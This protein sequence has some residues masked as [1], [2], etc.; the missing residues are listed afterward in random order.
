MRH[1]HQKTPYEYYPPYFCG[2]IFREILALS[3]T[4][5]VNRT[6]PVPGRWAESM[7]QYVAFLVQQSDRQAEMAATLTGLEI[8]NLLALLDLV[9]GAGDAEATIDLATSLYQLLHQ[10]GR[11]RLLARVG[12][13]R[14]VAAQSLARQPGDG[15]THA[16]FD[17]EADRIQQQKDGG[18]LR[19]AL[20]G[21]EAL[22]QRA[23]AAG[24]SAYPAADYDLAMA[25]WLLARIHKTASGFERALP[26]LDEARQ[27]F[28]TVERNEPG[29]GAERMAS[30]CLAER[31]DC[32]LF[33][34]RLDESAAAYEQNIALAERL[35]DE[36]QVAVGKGNLGTVRLYQRRYPE[37]LAASA[38]ARERFARLDEP[39]T[40]AVSWHQTGRAYQESG[41]PEAAE[42]AYRQALAF[43]VRLGDAARQA[44]TLG[45]LGK[46]Y[47]DVLNRPEDATAFERQSADLFGGIGDTANEGRVRGNLAVTLR[48]LRRLD[49]ARREVQRAIECM[50]QFGH[51]VEPWKTWAILSDIET[52]AGNPDP[53]AAAR[54]KAL[55]AYL[56]YR[57]A[58]GENHCPQ[59][60]I[61]LAVA[62]RLRAR[63]PAQA[64]TL[65]AELAQ[66]LD[67]PEQL[68]PFLKPL[69]A[70]CTGSRDPA[71]AQTPGLDYT[72]SAELLLLIE[73]LPP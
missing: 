3:S 8:P 44:S 60:R 73:T 51:A 41:N 19:E 45:Q 2:L 59:G 11:P 58:G 22:L 40:V 13:V 63:D 28:E 37:A 25:C 57:R 34:R 68:R 38:E 1:I 65:L 55:A 20:A 26:L 71:L 67:L 72:M 49:E 4:I 33:L 18:R 24:E 47:G 14:D 52:D 32:L 50:A 29:C 64:R 42:D 27:R 53:A 16:R 31:G 46:L 9:Q 69:D 6:E 7:G 12:H 66:N 62:E 48:R 36:R 39:G 54:S 10:L 70:L 23:R 30:A 5:S 15:W 43:W 35:A 61:A 56:D 17:A 21:A